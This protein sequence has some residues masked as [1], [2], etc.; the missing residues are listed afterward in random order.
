LAENVFNNK[1]SEG[2]N[3]N[4]NAEYESDDKKTK[5]QMILNSEADTNLL[6]NLNS[7]NIYGK[8]YSYLNNNTSSN[9]SNNNINSSNNNLNL[10]SAYYNPVSI[11]PNF[12]F[13]GNNNE[14]FFLDEK[15]RIVNF[16]EA[17]PVG[18]FNN[19]KLNN[20]DYLGFETNFTL[21][22]DVCSHKKNEIMNKQAHNK[23]VHAYESSEDN[24]MKF[25]YESADNNT[26]EYSLF[27]PVK[28]N[29]STIN[30][31]FENKNNFEEKANL[32]DKNFNKNVSLFNGK[33]HGEADKQ[34]SDKPNY[35]Q[36]EILINEQSDYL[37]NLKYKEDASSSF[38]K[39]DD[40]I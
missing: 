4:W 6:N 18:G 22:G 35:E 1:E 29:L 16:P 8:N 14:N 39:F 28:N 13:V 31:Y 19:S 33:S 34:N 27:N 12:N 11:T 20:N 26:S 2:S 24:K 23:N 15:D 3:M 5:R 38:K 36:E 9:T 10:Y 30:K 7:K 25:S 37:D 40:Y 17:N 32:N 21:N